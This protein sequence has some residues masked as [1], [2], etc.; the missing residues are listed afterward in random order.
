MMRDN[1]CEGPFS[2]QYIIIT[3]TSDV[4]GN[5]NYSYYVSGQ[6]APAPSTAKRSSA[7]RETSPPRSDAGSPLE[8]SRGAT[9]AKKVRSVMAKSAGYTAFTSPSLFRQLYAESLLPKDAADINP[10]AAMRSVRHLRR[11]CT[12]SYAEINH[13]RKVRKYTEMFCRRKVR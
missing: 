7:L 11:L 4:S 1:V 12:G 13:L 3:G 9:L 10:D 2:N 8:A 5:F 6:K